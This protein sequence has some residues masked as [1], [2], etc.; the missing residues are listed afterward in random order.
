MRDDSMVNHKADKDKKHTQF[1]QSTFFGEP[2]SPG[3]A[4]SDLMISHSANLPDAIIVASVYP[5]SNNIFLPIII[6]WLCV[7]NIYI[8]LKRQNFV[9][10]LAQT[11]KTMWY[12][13]V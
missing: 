4:P 6:I 3:K 9:Y 7:L 5:L 13:K 1:L 11:Y 8:S 12:F 2:P 10:I